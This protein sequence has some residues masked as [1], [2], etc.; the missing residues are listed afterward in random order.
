LHWYISKKSSTAN[1][2]ALGDHY[3]THDKPRVL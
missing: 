3:A 2:T 1:S